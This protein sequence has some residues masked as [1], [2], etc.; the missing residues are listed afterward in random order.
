MVIPWLS[1]VAKVSSPYLSGAKNSI[2]AMQ[3]LLLA[4]LLLFASSSRLCLRDYIIA[5]NMG[6]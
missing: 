5:V 6:T 1:R 4:S 3:E 2:L